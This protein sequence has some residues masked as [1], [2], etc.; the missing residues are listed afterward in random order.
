MVLDE[1]WIIGWNAIEKS[2]PRSTDSMHCLQDGP[3]LSI[4]SH[5]NEEMLY[6]SES[7]E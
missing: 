4:V 6:L 7:I 5:D 3:D 2:N 1:H